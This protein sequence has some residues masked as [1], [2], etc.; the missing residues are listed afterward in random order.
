MI[1]QALNI[2][3]RRPWTRAVSVY[4]AAR[5]LLAP[6]DFVTRP[7]VECRRRESLKITSV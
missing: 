6:G 5:A 4:N 7:S 2:L 1:R 3:D